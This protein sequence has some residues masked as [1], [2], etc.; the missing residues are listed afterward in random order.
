MPIEKSVADIITASLAR[1]GVEILFSQS[2]PSAALL[3][4]EGLAGPEGDAS[5]RITVSRGP[6]RTR[7]VLPPPRAAATAR[8]APISAKSS[9]APRLGSMHAGASATA[10]GTMPKAS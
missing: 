8:G 2:L 10:P 1:H 4:A 6:Y 7:G 5:V 9:A 3:A